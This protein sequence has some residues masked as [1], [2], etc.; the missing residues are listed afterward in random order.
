MASLN[1]G[2]V[3]GGSASPWVTVVIPTYNCAA[4][5]RLALES[6]VAQS[7]PAWRAVVVNNHSTDDTKAV[8]ASFGDDR[9]ELV[10]F[11]N[12]GVIAAS[13]NEGIR[14]AA[15]EWV[16]FLDA[17]DLWEPEKLA[18]CRRLAADSG[19]VAHDV[20]FAAEDDRPRW[21]RLQR[22]WQGRPLDLFLRRGNEL[23]TSA[24]LVRR[25]LL[26]ALGGFAEDQALVTTE[27]FDLWL[28][29]AASGARFALHPAPL[30]TILVREGSAS[31][32]AKRHLAANLAV[33][34]RH[35]GSSAAGGGGLWRRVQVR[36]LEAM[37]IYGAGRSYQRFGHHRE[38][39]GCLVRSFGR[40]PFYGRTWVGLGL[41]A[42]TVLAKTLPPVRF[43]KQPQCY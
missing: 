27:D 19:L 43:T 37:V 15:T 10:D 40:W 26:D 39:F 36:R 22:P 33:I 34:E 5:L 13:R 8:V 6:L 16:A 9:I 18:C 12:H 17:D 21:R 42:V 4:Y 7:D 20:W 31:R 32:A 1:S 25:R 41:L 23:V 30:G 14:R 11:H 24:V 38:A 2:P 35:F 29:L 3:V 28:R